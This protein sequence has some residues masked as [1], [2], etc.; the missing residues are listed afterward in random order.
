[1]PII[2]L[3]S[4]EAQNLMERDYRLRHLMQ[5]GGGAE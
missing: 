1:M 4:P 3:E 2:M 5:A